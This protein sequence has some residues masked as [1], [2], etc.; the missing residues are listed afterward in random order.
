MKPK[1]KEDASRSQLP[2]I[3]GWAMSIYKAQGQTL[4]RVRIDLA[5]ILKTD[6]HMWL[7]LVQHLPKHFRF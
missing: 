6:M 4:P 1:Y 5:D 7:F 2:L 3:Y